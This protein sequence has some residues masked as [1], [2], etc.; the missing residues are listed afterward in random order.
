[1]GGVLSARVR[2]FGAARGMVLR[3]C[4]NFI[5]TDYWSVILGLITAY[6]PKWGSYFSLIPQCPQYEVPSNA[7][8]TVTRKE[9]TVL[10]PRVGY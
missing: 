5:V 4:V 6:L 9:L 3:Y 1:M 7:I 8:C 10:E 2:P